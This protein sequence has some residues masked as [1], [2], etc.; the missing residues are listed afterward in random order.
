M[1]ASELVSSVMKRTTV[2]VVPDTTIR[3]V[4]E[5]LSR[6]EI[7]CVV[8]RGAEDPAGLVSERDLV[9]A[10]ADDADLDGDRASDI[11]AYD[12]VCLAPDQHLS[13]AARTMIE[14]GIRHL[15]VLD[16]HTV[17]GIVSMRDVLEHLLD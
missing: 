12:I 11:M 10:I 17:V 2:S 1:S 7:G 13:D 15:P 3:E 4:A 6:E 9:R 16:G 5:I 14:G 8:V